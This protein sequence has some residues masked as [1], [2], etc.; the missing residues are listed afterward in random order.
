M[1]EY[2]CTICGE[3]S[4]SAAEIEHMT[5]PFCDKCGGAIKESEEKKNEADLCTV[6]KS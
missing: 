5:E 4:Y 3:K 2:T 6:R 1:K